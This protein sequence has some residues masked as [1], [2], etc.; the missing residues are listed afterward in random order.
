MLFAQPD[1]I[2]HVH[3]KPVADCRRVLWNYSGS[4]QIYD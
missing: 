1:N 2:C 4:C 3:V